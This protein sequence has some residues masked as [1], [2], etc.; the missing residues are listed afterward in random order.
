MYQGWGKYTGITFKILIMCACLHVLTSI[1]IL[2]PGWS[3]AQRSSSVV[4][5]AAPA[6]RT[7]G[8]PHRPST[9]FYRPDSSPCWNPAVLPGSHS[10]QKE[11]TTLPEP[12]INTNVLHVT[13]PVYCNCNSSKEIFIKNGRRST[14]QTTDTG[15]SGGLKHSQPGHWQQGVN[16]TLIYTPKCQLS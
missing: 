13:R 11:K 8:A 16:L 10:F 7:C 9:G 3:S 15:H 5:R 2:S 1:W 14:C 12:F 4:G 6:W